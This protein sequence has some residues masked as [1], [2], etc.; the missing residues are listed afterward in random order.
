MEISTQDGCTPPYD[1]QVSADY[2][3]EY[4]NLLANDCDT[5]SG[6]KHGGTVSTDE[7]Y[8]FSMSVT[9]ESKLSCKGGDGQTY[10]VELL[11]G[12]DRR[13]GIMDNFCT[14]IEA[15]TWDGFHEDFTGSGE[16]TNL[17]TITLNMDNCA[18]DM[19]I[20]H[21]ECMN[22]VGQIANNCDT[23]SGD[24]HGGLFDVGNCMSF[25]MTVYDP[26]DA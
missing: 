5:D 23:D 25:N 13:S 26:S 12:N 14:N 22:Y 2:C 6:N 21:D 3:K 15:N 16:T 20:S 4:M 7:C 8:I 1:G 17:C 24:K 11:N 9:S 19:T 10:P 18:D